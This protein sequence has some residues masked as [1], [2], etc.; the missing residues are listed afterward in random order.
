[1]RAAH[2]MGLC[3]VVAT[4]V[5]VGHGITKAATDTDVSKAAA[6]VDAVGNL[7]VPDNYRAAYQALGSWAVAADEGRG[8]KELHVV[9]A[10]P[11]SVEAYRKDGRFPDGAV[12]VKEVFKTATQEMT[13]GTVSYADE[14][15]GWFVMVKGDAS[16]FPAH[17]LWGDGWGWSWFDATNPSKT[18]STN[19]QLQAGLQILQCAGAGDRMGLRQWI[20]SVRPLAPR[21]AP[22]VKS[23]PRRAPDLP[24]VLPGRDMSIH[25][26]ALPSKIPYRLANLY[27]KS[28]TRIM[29]RAAFFS[30]RFAELKIR[31]T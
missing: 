20:S 11:G 27:E 18:T 12:L 23:T 30:S 15:K 22:R 19:D 31:D 17:A 24:S 2:I 29:V 7:R 28:P 25:G 4:I 6:V 9:Y 3:G 26:H 10:S 14:L 21:D 8:S 16:R 1:M 5:V 13:T